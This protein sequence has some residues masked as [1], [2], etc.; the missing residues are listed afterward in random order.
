MEDLKIIEL[1]WQRDEQAITETSQKY[2][3]FCNH[4]AMNILCV[5]EDAEECVSDTYHRA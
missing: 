4:I 5:R 1:Y 2:G 3:R